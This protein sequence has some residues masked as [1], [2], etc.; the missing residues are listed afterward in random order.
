MEMLKS[1]ERLSCLYSA[2]MKSLTIEICNLKQGVRKFL[3]PK[4][5]KIL[6]TLQGDF[7]F[8][9]NDLP[10]KKAEKGDFFFI[11]SSGQFGLTALS[12][13][14]VLIMRLPGGGVICESCNVQ[15][16]YKDEA[17]VTE[18]EV[19]D[20]ADINMLKINPLMWT[21][22]HGLNESI[23]SGLNCRGYFDNKI[24]EMLIILK[25]SYPRK[26]LQSF[27]YLILSPNMAFMEYVRGNNGK[28]NSVA[29][30]AQAMGM[31]PK[32]FSVVFLKVFKE[33]PQ[34]WMAREKAKLVY[35]ELRSGNKSFAQ[36]ADEK[37]FSSQQ[38]FN[39]FCQ[40]EFGKSPK[41]IRHEENV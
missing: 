10:E 29:E 37:G 15:Q 33:T 26:E 36:I 24:K 23:K 31:T 4:K 28:Y 3:S 40:R 18:E 14:N 32:N 9:Y 1:Q 13:C 6:F 17:E 19:N 27:F 5:N 11:P 16:L 2:C 35:A 25:A 22:L 21:F 7:D 34:R 12:E 20:A 38:H 39:K 8:R 41:K 30:F